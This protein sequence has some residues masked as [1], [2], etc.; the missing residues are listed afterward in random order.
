MTGHYRAVGAALAAVA[1][2]GAFAVAPAAAGPRTKPPHL[3]VANRGE[4]FRAAMGTY[5][6]CYADGDHSMCVVADVAYPP[7]SGRALPVRQG[8]RIVLRPHA[9]VKSM[10]AST[11]DFHRYPNQPKRV[12]GKH[13]V[14]TLRIAKGVGKRK[15]LLVDV[16]YAGD[17]NSAEFG[18]GIRPAEKSQGL[19]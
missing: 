19:P 10:E 5:G 7:K 16:Q 8:D 18:F 2:L 6:W 13:H 15:N 12:K 11:Y 3:R 14:W 1:A 17:G 4:S 9:K